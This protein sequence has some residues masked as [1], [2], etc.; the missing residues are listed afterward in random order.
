MNGQA[1][2]GITDLDPG[3]KN[4][5]TKIYSWAT[6]KQNSVLGCLS[7]AESRAVHFY[8]TIASKY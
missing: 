1:G 6:F 2:L 4:W 3:N 7:K 5:A 8:F